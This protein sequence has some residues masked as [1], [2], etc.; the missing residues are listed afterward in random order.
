MERY[1]VLD[2]TS[3]H[4][5]GEDLCTVL[6]CFGFVDVFHEHALVLEDVTL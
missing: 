1:L 6:L 3:L 4:L 2:A 5:V